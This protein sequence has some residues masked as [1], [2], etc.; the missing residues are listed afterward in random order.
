MAQHEDDVLGE[1]WEVAIGMFYPVA[2]VFIGSG[3]FSLSF[4]R[5]VNNFSMDRE[6]DVKNRDM[7]SLFK[8]NA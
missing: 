1:P 4:D 2:G 6:A 3:L 8:E 5:L 7:A